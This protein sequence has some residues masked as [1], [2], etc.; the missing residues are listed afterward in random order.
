[1]QKVSYGTKE[2]NTP[3]HQVFQDCPFCRLYAPSCCNWA[4][5]AAGVLMGRTASHQ[6]RALVQAKIA[7]WLWQGQS[8]CGQGSA[9]WAWWFVQRRTTREYHGGA[10]GAVKVDGEYQKW[11][12]LRKMASINMSIPRQSS[13]RSQPLTIHPNISQYVSF[14]YGTDTFKLLPLC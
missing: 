11:H 3:F 9:F 14:T 8:C 6:G 7:I 12:S 5:T 10:N 2:H 4:V 1:M 13:Y